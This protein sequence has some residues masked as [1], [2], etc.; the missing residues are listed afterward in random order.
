MMLLFFITWGAFLLFSSLTIVFQC[1]KKKKKMDSSQKLSLKSSMR[2]V[3]MDSR[4]TDSPSRIRSHGVGPSNKKKNSA[5]KNSTSRRHKLEI[6]DPALGTHSGRSEESD[7]KSRQTG[8]R[9]REK[10]ELEE[11]ATIELRERLREELEGSKSAVS[12][13]AGT[14]TAA[15]S[16]Q[17]THVSQLATTSTEGTTAKSVTQSSYSPSLMLEEFAKPVQANKGADVRSKT[18]SV[19]AGKGEEKEVK[20]QEDGEVKAPEKDRKK[21]S[22]IPKLKKPELKGSKNLASKNAKDDMKKVKG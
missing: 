14:C 20:T 22:K 19:I 11:T 5:N 18:I 6:L 21:M 4:K 7:M 9:R 10:E 3:K 1:L 12:S 2:S 17:R 8:Q 13:T 16:T 15:T